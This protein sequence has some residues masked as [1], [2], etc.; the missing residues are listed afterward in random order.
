M[1]FQSSMQWQRNLILAHHP[2]PPLGIWSCLSMPWLL[3]NDNSRN[4]NKKQTISQCNRF[5]ST[6]KVPPQRIYVSRSIARHNTSASLVVCSAASWS[7]PIPSLV[8]AHLVMVRLSVA[9]GRRHLWNPLLQPLQTYQLLGPGSSDRFASPQS[10]SFRS[11]LAY[12][13]A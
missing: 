2:A 1:L 7:Y 4:K 13:T 11:I 3:R 8:C 10:S 12:G 6:C 5:I 9:R